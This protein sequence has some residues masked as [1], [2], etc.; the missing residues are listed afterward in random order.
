M[1]ITI[2]SQ[3]IFK[4]IEFDKKLENIEENHIRLFDG[5]TLS[6]QKLLYAIDIDLD[7]L[8]DKKYR[9]I[10]IEHV[11]TY[12]ESWIYT[13]FHGISMYVHYVNEREWEKCEK[14]LSILEEREMDDCPEPGQMLLENI[15]EGW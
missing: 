14:V 8:S 3:N 2:D 7:M 13:T 1:A 9:D 10:I 5:M 15:W 12:R 4:N 6:D 11:R